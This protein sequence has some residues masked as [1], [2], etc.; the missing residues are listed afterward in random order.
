MKDTNARPENKRYATSTAAAVDIAVPSH[1]NRTPR[2]A[3]RSCSGP[4]SAMPWCIFVTER[5]LT[6]KLI[7]NTMTSPHADAAISEPKEIAWNGSDTE[8]RIATRAIVRANALNTR[9]STRLTL[10]VLVPAK[11]SRA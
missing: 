4:Y 2:L 5:R 11:T 6:M 1:L 7:T 3:C 10:Y 9:S 8:M